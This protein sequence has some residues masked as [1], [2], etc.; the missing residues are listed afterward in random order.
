[1]HAIR[2]IL[3]AVKNPASGSSPALQK[4]VQLARALHADLELF[5]SIANPVYVDAYPAGQSLKKLKGGIRS[6]CREGL[7]SMAAAIARRGLN[8]STCVEWDYPVHEAIV[9]RAACIKA[10]LIVADQHVGRHIAPGLLQLPD[11][12]LLRLSPIPVLLVKSTRPYRRPTV[13]AAVD[14]AHAYAKPAKLDDEILHVGLRIS[15]ALHGNLHAIHAYIPLPIAP[16][17]DYSLNPDTVARLQQ[18]TEAAAERSF[19]QGLRSA[20]IPPRHRHLV[21]GTPSDAIEQTALATRSAIVVMG[22]MARSGLRRLFI[23]NTAETLL[24]RLTCDVLI[25]KPLRF[26]PHLQRKRRGARL[27]ALAALP[28]M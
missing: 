8:V 26:Q 19:E 13:L 1:M 3:V 24:D 17:P 10:G 21:A 22:A 27:T 25:V 5:H 15:A 2:H 6:E 7:E 28:G 20:K 9:R 11:W 18:Q 23:G 4:A 12:E 14:P 16:F